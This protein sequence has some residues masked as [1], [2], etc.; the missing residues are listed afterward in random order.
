MLDLEQG[1]RDIFSEA[2]ERYAWGVAAELLVEFESNSAHTIYRASACSQSPCNRPRAVHDRKV[3]DDKYRLKR[4]KRLLLA[5]V[6]PRLRHVGRP[7]AIWV[8]A[9]KELGI[10]LG[11][12]TPLTK[13]EHVALRW[14]RVVR[15]KLL[16]GER[17]SHRGPKPTRWLRIAKELGIDLR[18]KT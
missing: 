6:R 12:T 18:R 15:E 5:G 13:K 7:P 8:R 11:R 16:R 3:S 1:V 10:D 4:C 2:Q 9:A 17:P 14:D